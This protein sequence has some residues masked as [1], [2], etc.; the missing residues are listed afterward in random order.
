MQ[1]VQCPLVATYTFSRY[2]L[3]GTNFRGFLPQSAKDNLLN[4]IDSCSGVS[5]LRG[6]RPAKIKSANNFGN[7]TQ[8][9]NLSPMNKYR[10]YRNKSTGI[11]NIATTVYKH[12]SGVER[13]LPPL[14]RSLCA[15]LLD[16]W[17]PVPPGHTDT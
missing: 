17:I 10:R 2:F 8:S 16:A 11:H 9:R 5:D 6:F 13:S 12:V 15:R 7:T 1:Y 14:R 3:Q 4:C